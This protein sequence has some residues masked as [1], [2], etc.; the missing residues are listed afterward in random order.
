MGGRKPNTIRVIAGE[1]RGRT[2][3]YPRE[4]IVR[5]TMDRTREALFSSIQDRLVGA[6]FADLFCAAGGVGIEALSRGASYVEFV[7]SGHAA[8]DCL[9][10]NLEA[11]AV[12]G[13]R[14][15]AYRRDGFEYLSAGGLSRAAID[16]IFADPPYD[17]DDGRRL[18]EYFRGTDYDKLSMIVLEHRDPID[19]RPLTGLVHA[20]TRKYGESRLSFWIRD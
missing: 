8:T 1:Y 6:R 2:L 10:R 4:R 18:L 17:T 5:P 12:P 15:E 14:Y 13:D 11:C 3:V 9:R 19:N 20:R 7:D 16:T